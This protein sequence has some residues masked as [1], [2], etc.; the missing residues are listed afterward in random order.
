MS[1]INPLKVI[2]QIEVLKSGKV[3]DVSNPQN[4]PN[5][6]QPSM[7]EHPPNTK[8]KKPLSEERRQHME[9]MRQARM[10]NKSKTE[11]EQSQ[12]KLLK[13]LDNIDEK[14][15]L[16][17]DKILK[18]LDDINNKL[19]NNDKIKIDAPVMV[20]KPKPIV[21]HS[22]EPEKPYEDEY[23]KKKDVI[24]EK[25]KKEFIKPFGKINSIVPQNWGDKAYIKRHQI[26]GMSM[27]DFVNKRRQ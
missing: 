22:I 5:I 24:L 6:Q 19:N 8:V 15:K 1:S 11:I 18:T 21:E 26:Q 17:I 7:P 13:K 10:N 27:I 2:K 4:L 23:L 20:E 25:E 9:K 12:H 3:K 16:N 14:D